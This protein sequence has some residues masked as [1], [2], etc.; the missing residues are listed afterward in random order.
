MAG[1]EGAEIVEKDRRR[2]KRGGQCEEEWKE[3]ER[4]LSLIRWSAFT[5]TQ[6]DNVHVHAN[7]ALQL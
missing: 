7:L 5:T 3:E 6:H 4:I 2:G 1:G